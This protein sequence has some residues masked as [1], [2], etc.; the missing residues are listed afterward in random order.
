MSSQILDLNTFQILKCRDT[1]HL[2]QFYPE[3]CLITS[4]SGIGTKNVGAW[5]EQKVQAEQLRVQLHLLQSGCLAEVPA[6][7]KEFYDEVFRNP[8]RSFIHLYSTLKQKNGYEDVL[9]YPIAIPFTI[10]YNDTVVSIPEPFVYWVLLR[11][12]ETADG[13]I[14][15]KMAT[16]VT[17]YRR[18]KSQFN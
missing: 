3:I 13:S 16:L 9:F 10:P 11:Q 1:E 4:T 6:T 5:I 2:L 15:K 17:G 7:H 18:Y 12:S 8:L 14:F